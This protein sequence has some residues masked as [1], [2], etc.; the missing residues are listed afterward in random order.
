[1]FVQLTRTTRIVGWGHTT[2]AILDVTPRD[3]LYEFDIT[4]FDFKKDMEVGR[5]D[6]AR[7]SVLC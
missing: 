6:A 1:M 4:V 3:N 7:I 5:I 2:G